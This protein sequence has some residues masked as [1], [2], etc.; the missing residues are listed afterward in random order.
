MFSACNLCDEVSCWNGKMCDVHFVVIQWQK[1]FR[2]SCGLSLITVLGP[3]QQP[4]SLC[5]LSVVLVAIIRRNVARC[6]MHHSTFVSDS[7]SVQFVYY[8]QITASTLKT[9]LTDVSQKLYCLLR[10]WIGWK[11][12]LICAKL[13]KQKM[14]TFYTIMI[15]VFV[16]AKLFVIYIL[17]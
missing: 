9:F 14:T 5:V 1:C 15:S 3:L 12:L 11:A 17:L 6:K 8:D 4:V 2:S 13:N 16:T 7:L 10:V